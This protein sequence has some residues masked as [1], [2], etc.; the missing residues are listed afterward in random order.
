VIKETAS[1]ARSDRPTSSSSWTSSAPATPGHLETQPAG[2]VTAPPDRHRHRLAERGIGFCSLQEAIDTT[3]P[4]GKL[5]FHVFAALAKF[6]RDLVR[7]RTS[8]GMAAACACGRHGGGPSVMTAHK[9]QV[10]WEMYASKEHTGAAIAKTLRVSR[11]SIY[12]HLTVP[13]AD[14]AGKALEP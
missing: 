5:V 12:R 2:S 7:E 9:L 4:G 14:Q 8:A 10:A 13:A 1:G 11:A 3:T 6:E